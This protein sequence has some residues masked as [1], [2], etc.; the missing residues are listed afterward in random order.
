MPPFDPD[1]FLAQP[2]QSE[3]LAAS[4]FNPDVFLAGT[5]APA[6]ADKY[7]QA[8]IEERNRLVAA[9][10]PLPE[11]YTRRA[12]SGPL[13]GWGD[14][15]A[16]AMSTPLEMARRGVGPVEGYRYA[17]ARETLADQAARERTGLAGDAVEVLG[18][19]ALLP[20]QV[21]ANP[22]SAVLGGAA[23]GIRGAAARIAG[24]GAE[25]GVLGAVSGAGNA[26]TVADIPKEAFKSGVTGAALGAPFGVAAN[27]A[28]R[29]T[30]RV[31][32]A[33]EL[34]AIG[35]SMYNLRDALPVGY[36]LQRAVVEPTADMAQ[37]LRN[38]YGRDVPNTVQS[39]RNISGEAAG[40]VAAVAAANAG[41]NPNAVAT[42]YSGQP[43]SGEAIATPRDINSLRRQIYDEGAGKVFDPASQRWVDSGSNTDRMAATIASKALGQVVARPDPRYLS[44]NTSMRDALAAAM[45]DT[46]GRGNFGAAFRSKAVTD[47]IEDASRASGNT[48]FTDRFK[49][50]VNKAAGSGEFERLS[51]EEIAALDRVA[52]VAGWGKSISDIGN[53]MGANSKAGAALAAAGGFGAGYGVSQDPQTALAA[54]AGTLAGGRILR[55]IGDK[56]ARSK[57]ERFAEDLRKRSP[58]YARRVATSPMEAGPGLASPL[59]GLRTALTLGNEGAIRD[60]LAR[61]LVYQSTG[62][63]ME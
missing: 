3:P 58:E 44:R 13:L 61:M 2:G 19:I 50:A 14:E 40:D 11:G 42:R 35:A 34:D 23:K 8:A 10:V 1:A 45:L 56:V 62:Q 52:R 57:A 29:S 27:V 30:A 22:L 15:A 39:L 28:R 5:A 59:S 55:S 43:N 38:Q 37:M 25:S 51:N 60:A 63:R 31:P 21:F 32:T 12:M 7:Q 24:Y 18:G 48:P 6:G 54:A 20:G 17:K 47:A 33:D 16:A 26:E 49:A 53:L 36:N 46:Q 41:R 4:T 9:G